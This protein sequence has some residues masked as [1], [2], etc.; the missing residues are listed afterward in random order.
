MTR[1][2]PDIILY[3]GPGSGK[4]TQAE[5]LVQKIK[6]EHLNMGALLRK[7]VTTKSSDAVRT[8]K[9]MLAGK[10]VPMNITNGLAEKFVTKQKSSAQ[11]V[12]D[13]YPRN[14][15]QVKFLDKLLAQT[16]RQAVLLYIKLPVTVAKARLIKRAQIEHRADDLDPKALSARI[17]VFN[18]EAK[19]LLAHYR[20]T[21]RLITINGD[22]T[23][24]KVQADILKA[25]KAWR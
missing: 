25:I 2:N 15:A 18:H 21:K 6:A 12:L 20:K 13:G 14:L 1:S 3:G 19:E 17:Q 5:R 22:Q 11:I 8:K 4:S 23:V 9:I 24:A 10:L 7:F 16:H